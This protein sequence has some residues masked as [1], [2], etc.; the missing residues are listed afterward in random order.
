MRAIEFVADGH[1][2]TPI[3]I[4][5]AP[6]TAVVAQQ[7]NATYRTYPPLRCQPAFSTLHR[8]PFK[9]RS[10]FSL[11]F[12]VSL[13]LQNPSPS[14][15][16]S[17]SASSSPDIDQPHASRLSR[18]VASHGGPEPEPERILPP[19][20][21]TLSEFIASED[22][23]EREANI[24][25]MFHYLDFDGSGYIELWELKRN[26]IKLR[27]E[28]DFSH[29]LDQSLQESNQ[30]GGA[31]LK[32]YSA[33]LSAEILAHYLFDAL[34]QVKDEERMQLSWFG[35]IFTRRTADEILDYEAFKKL[36]LKV[37]E[38]AWDL[39]NQIDVTRDGRVTAAEIK[40]AALLEGIKMKLEAAEDFVR[41]LDKP[42][43]DG[44]LDFKEFRRFVF[45]IPSIL[46]KDT[47]LAD[48]FGAYEQVY[49]TSLDLDSVP[50]GPQ[51]DAV[52]E[53][54]FR[55]FLA[56]GIAGATSRT[57]TAPL[58]RIRIY[59]QIETATDFA[60]ARKEGFVKAVKH[61]IRHFRI[62]IASIYANG[63]IASFYRGN[64]L[65]C[66][67]IMPEAGIGFY[68]SEHITTAFKTLDRNRRDYA[69]PQLTDEEKD[70][71]E[72]EREM[73]GSAQVYVNAAARRFFAGAVGG[74]TGVAVAYPIETIRM[75]LMSMNRLGAGFD[76]SLKVTKSALGMIDS[77]AEVVFRGVK[78]PGL[79]GFGRRIGLAS[80]A[81]NRLPAFVA[82]FST[83]T[84]PQPPPRSLTVAA[85]QDIYRSAGFLGF[86]RGIIP[87]LLGVAP[88]MGIQSAVFD[89]MKRTWKRRTRW[90]DRHSVGFGTITAFGALS[91]SIAAVVVYPL[92]LVRVR[93]QAQGSAS[94]PK[95]YSGA[96]DCF[97]QT[98]RNEG[99]RGFYRGLG[100]SLSK[101]APAT[102]LAFVTYEMAKELLGVA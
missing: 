86:Y 11:D 62:A 71:W 22:P 84:P 34:K 20:R 98:Y 28:T 69:M 55:F 92:Q 88:Y 44:T 77:H 66:L 32:T 82:A 93:M 70:A 95:T 5:A 101:V 57:L 23:V 36:M 14:C 37:E 75:R 58:D 18:F 26:L 12:P 102:G 17:S 6:A 41:A 100:V 79:D 15:A 51:K 91:G 59:F 49:S 50:W 30:G 31:H 39:F 63:G 97:L 83:S 13:S 81:F 87:A 54:K 2:Y 25:A 85:I 38:K 9:D 27:G 45:T 74:M 53:E 65:N 61:V 29:E 33:G 89:A 10:L 67:R 16:M 78:L 1:S 68:V 72:L 64:A 21:L 94:H 24:K 80:S 8:S 46:R 52:K 43:Y 35:T 48:I 4:Y 40:R 96:M 7:R 60:S 73:D 90:Q 47:G 19:P 42:P 99:F 56:G 3:V 76:S